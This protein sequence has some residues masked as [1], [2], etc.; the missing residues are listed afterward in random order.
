[1]IE[2]S[3]TILVKP[4]FTDNG[5][6]EQRNGLIRSNL[7]QSRAAIGTEDAR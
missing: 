3:S 1:M 4:L 2:L 7:L 6:R 5:T